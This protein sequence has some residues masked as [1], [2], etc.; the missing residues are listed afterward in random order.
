M[1][2]SIYPFDEEKPHVG[3][4]RES[5]FRRGDKAADG[6]ARKVVEPPQRLLK[7]LAADVLEQPVDPVEQRVLQV[8]GETQR[9]VVEPSSLAG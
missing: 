4:R 2:P 8:L 7:W 1:N 5:A 6:D 9:L 3:Q